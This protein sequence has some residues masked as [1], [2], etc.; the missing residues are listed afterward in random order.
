MSEVASPVFELV[1]L[2]G[3]GGTGKTSVTA[4]LAVLAG[5]VALADCDVDASNLELVL[6]PQRLGHEAFAGAARARVEPAVCAGCTECVDLCRFEAIAME[7]RLGGAL[8][9]RVDTPACEGCGVCVHFCPAG[10]IRLEPVEGGEWFRS[11]TRFGP[12]VHARL[13]PGEGNSGLL[14][15]LVRERARQEARAAGRRLL[16]VDGP[17]G[18]GCPAIASLTGA[19]AVLAVTEPTLSGEHDLERLL[20]LCRHFALPVEVCVNKHDINPEVTER[21]EACCAAAGAPVV[22]RIPYD[23]AVTA[24]QRAGRPVVEQGGPAAEALRELWARLALRRRAAG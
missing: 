18:V 15:S 1:V 5:A 2:S 10:A 6:E 22:G 14:V 19:N 8:L 4:S 7:E 3:K 13:R 12:L 20:A 16:L 9:A 21:I 23:P 11:A 24:A 17:P